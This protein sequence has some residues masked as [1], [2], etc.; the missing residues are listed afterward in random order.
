MTDGD[1]LGGGVGAW[2]WALL[3]GSDVP[4]LG[5]I[6]R[7][8]SGFA[9]RLCSVMVVAIHEVP[10]DLRILADVWLDGAAGIWTKL[11]YRA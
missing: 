8:V 4:D 7:A 11:G 9:S 6:F 3:G 5:R 2:P 1:A 10:H